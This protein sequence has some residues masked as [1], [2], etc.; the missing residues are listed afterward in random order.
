MPYISMNALAPILPYIQI[1]LAILLVASVLMQQS[2]A[3]LGGA[4]GGDSFS[5][6]HHTR[7]GPEKFLFNSSVV[8]SILFVLSAVISLLI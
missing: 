4:F 3:G 8:I 2:A 1:I 5:I 7:R 6:G